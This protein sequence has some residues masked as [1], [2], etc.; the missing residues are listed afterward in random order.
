MFVKNIQ[1]SHVQVCNF[2]V[3]YLSGLPVSFTKEQRLFV[4]KGTTKGNFEK[5][6]K[7]SKF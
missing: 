1:T 5:P 7:F 4:Y 2:Q 3:M 6:P